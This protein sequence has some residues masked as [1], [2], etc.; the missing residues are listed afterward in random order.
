[1]RINVPKWAQTEFWNEP[2]EGTVEFWA[3]RQFKGNICR[4]GDTL[5]FYFGRRKVAEAIVAFVEP[6]GQSECEHSGRF[7]NRWKV[8]WTPESFKDLRD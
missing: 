7:R 2:P 5:E 8:F 6:P 4:P 3:F 1:M